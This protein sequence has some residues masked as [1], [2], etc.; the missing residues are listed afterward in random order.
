MERRRFIGGAGLA[1]ILAAGRAPSVQAAQAIRWRLASHFPKA[2]DL[3]QDGV[4]TFTQAVKELSGGKF[5][6]SI[7]NADDLPSASGVLDGVQ[8]GSIECGHTSALYYIDKDETFALDC[9]IPFGLNARQMNAWML[10]GNGLSLLRDF[11]RSHGIVNFPM[12]NSGAQMGGWY[13]KPIRSPADF[14]NLKI[15]IT[16][17]GAQ[18][19]TRLGAKPSSISAGGIYKAL[20]QGR[21]DAAEWIGPY[22][23]LKLGIDRIAKYY[24]YPG[25]WDGSAQFSLYVNQRA[26]D[27]L[28]NE[29]KAIIEAATTIT[30]LDIQARYDAHNPTALRELVASGAQLTPFPRTVLEAAHKAALGLYAEFSEKNP[31]WKKIYASHAQF[32]KDQA[33]SWGFTETAYSNYMHRY[34]LEQTKTAARQRR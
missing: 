1:G 14:K 25:W 20:E 30:H 15:R 5:E 29:N 24:A 17:L 28:T 12:G 21:I 11:Y 18:I 13:R 9:A 6:I 10:E 2:M 34:A 19:F 16:G 31:R 26:Y 7:H 22:D 27:S 23:D 33:W 32:L 8:R 4:Q 3:L